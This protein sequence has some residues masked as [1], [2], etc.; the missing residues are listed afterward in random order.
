MKNVN[1]KVTN[2][3]FIVGKIYQYEY[4]L[5]A[6]KAIYTT[7]PNKA[8]LVPNS[9]YDPNLL[10][11]EKINGYLYDQDVFLIL[12][13]EEYSK[14]HTDLMYCKILKENITGWVLLD[15]DNISLLIE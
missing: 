9:N 6:Y 8:S 4:L 1:P 10:P 12:E 5:H 14:E 2:A 11:L 15:L 13:T 7:V 3:N